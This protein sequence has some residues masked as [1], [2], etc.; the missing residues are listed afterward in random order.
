M[1]LIPWAPG[2]GPSFEET[3]ELYRSSF[4][5]NELREEA[6]QRRIMKDPAYKYLLAR[7]KTDWVGLLLCWETKD[8]IYEGC[9]YKAASFAHVHP[10]YHRNTP[11]H[12]LV[13][14]S[15]PGPLSRETY[16]SFRA[17]L[18]NT[19]MKNPFAEESF[20]NRS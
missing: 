8:F 13:V 6:S 3:M 14:M 10:P 4:P 5:P 1:E 2:T 17:Y 18:E 19:V 9:G 16:E 11:G 12:E 7:E 20:A 15:A